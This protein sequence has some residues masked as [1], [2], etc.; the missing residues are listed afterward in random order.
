MVKVTYNTAQCISESHVDCNVGGMQCVVAVALGP[1]W[2]PSS[3]FQSKSVLSV[4]ISS[5]HSAIA[6]LHLRPAGHV[7]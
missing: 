3:W 7:C 4:F 2:D 5:S 1:R 6:A